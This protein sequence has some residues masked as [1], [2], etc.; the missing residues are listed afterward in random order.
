MNALDVGSGDARDPDHRNTAFDKPVDLEHLRRYTL[1]DKALEDEVLALFLA[2]LPVT[3]AS[4]KTAANPR[5]W[6]IA[7]HALKGSSRAVGAWRI[8]SLAQEA[9]A[10]AGTKGEAAACSAAIAK[11]E[12]AA[13]EASIF[14][15]S[16]AERS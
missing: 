15:Q 1:G 8:A 2:Q 16:C 5:D 13:S 11:L 9:E 4:L 14:V 6:K 12:A 10:L 7:A 3:I